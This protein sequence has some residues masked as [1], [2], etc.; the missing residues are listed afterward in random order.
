MADRTIS[1]GQI[2][3]YLDAKLE[4]VRKLK[5]KGRPSALK[6]ARK[7]L[8]AQLELSFA[9][10]QSP[11][12]VPWAANVL[13]W[14]DHKM[15]ETGTSKVL[16]YHGLLL[17]GA[18]AGAK[19]GTLKNDTFTA[20]LTTAQTHYGLKHQRGLAGGHTKSGFYLPA[21]PWYGW[22]EESLQAIRKAALEDVRKA[23]L[24]K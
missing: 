23:I 21:R 3:N 13:W 10:E 7:Q 11:G 12:G 20:T 1:I 16:T 19:K 24:G 15:A 22:T 5:E 4:R 14:H 9:K 17:K 18:V 8:Q 6:E 2:G